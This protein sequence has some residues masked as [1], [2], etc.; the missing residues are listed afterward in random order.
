MGIPDMAAAPFSSFTFG[1]PKT[2][3][4]KFWD[5]TPRATCSRSAR[6]GAVCAGM[7]VGMPE[8]KRARR[9]RIWRPGAASRPGSRARVEKIP[10]AERRGRQN[11]RIPVFQKADPQKASVS[12]SDVPLD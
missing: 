6:S 10:G 2:G 7:G 5:S 3:I 9:R 12:V 8:V 11:S 1:P 4:L